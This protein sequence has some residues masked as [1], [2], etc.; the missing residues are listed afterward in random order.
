[1]KISNKNINQKFLLEILNLSDAVYDGGLDEGFYFYPKGLGFTVQIPYSQ[2]STAV[3]VNFVLKKSGSRDSDKEVVNLS[4][5]FLDDIKEFMSELYTKHEL[6]LNNHDC[7]KQAL[8]KFNEALK[9][10]LSKN[11]PY[12]IKG[13]NENIS[14]VEDT[15]EYALAINIGRATFIFDNQKKFKPLRP[16]IVDCF[17]RPNGSK[18]NE[19]YKKVIPAYQ[20]SDYPIVARFSNINKTFD[21]IYSLSD[22]MSKINPQSATL[23]SSIILD[24]ELDKKDSAKTKR[25]KI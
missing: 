19:H 18:K 22:A 4:F 3:D 11:Y 14:L 23:L 10:P 25:P 24:I 20:V 13:D 2:Y 7:S 15:S 21:N 1:M 8:S 5:P 17:Y 9:T 16:I 6:M 12:T